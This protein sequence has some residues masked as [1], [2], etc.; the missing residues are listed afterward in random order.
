MS[1]YRNTEFTG[2]LLDYI[3]KKY[4]SHRKIP[5]F[6]ESQINELRNEFKIKLEKKYKITIKND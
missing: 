3:M 6:V 4:T 5:C 1:G 2:P